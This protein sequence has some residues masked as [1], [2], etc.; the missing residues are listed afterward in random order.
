MK[1]KKPIDID[2]IKSV[3]DEYDLFDETDNDQLIEKLLFVINN[4][5]TESERNLIL[6]YAE[7][8][9]LRKLSKVLGCSIGSVSTEINRIKSK[10]K[11]FFMKEEEKELWLDVAGYE[12]LYKV[13]NLGNVFSIKRNRLM[14]PQDNGLGYL[15]VGLTDCQGKRKFLLVHRLV[16]EAFLANP[17]NFDEINHKNENKSDNRA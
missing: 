6:S 13:S 8:S 15:I 3:Y 7:L 14:K 10:V 4:K 17:N 1:T 12:G 11:K 2:D 9:S 16:A 5:L